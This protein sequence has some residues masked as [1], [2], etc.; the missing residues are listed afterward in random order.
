M[1]I[2]KVIPERDYF[3]IATCGISPSLTK[4]PFNWFVCFSMLSKTSVPL[5]DIFS[6]AFVDITFKLFG[7]R[8]YSLDYISDTSNFFSDSCKHR[9]QSSPLN[10]GKPK[11]SEGNYGEISIE[12]TNDCFIFQI[13]STSASGGLIL[14]F[15]NTLKAVSEFP[16][17]PV[18]YCYLKEKHPEL[19]YYQRLLLSYR[20]SLPGYKF[21][22]KNNHGNHEPFVQWSIS[23][24][25][26]ISKEKLFSIWKSFGVFEKDISLKNR[27]SFS[28]IPKGFTTSN[29]LMYPKT[30]L[31]IPSTR[32]SNSIPSVNDI[33][34][35]L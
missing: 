3:G 31:E 14:G 23:S 28:D 16:L 15:L 26:G 22:H 5:D 11:I 12:D 30:E 2:P 1:K 10:L 4:Q 33:G 20:C 25:K 34:E 9:F 27:R 29:Y 6:V 13:D 18:T 24:V 8:E 35:F 19:N 17:V 32:I 7:T 21:W